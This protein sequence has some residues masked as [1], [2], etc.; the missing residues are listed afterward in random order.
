V[1]GLY[2]CFLAAIVLDHAHLVCPI[3][4][5]WSNRGF[6]E[7]MLERPEKFILL[8]ALCVASA[9]LVGEHVTTTREPAFRALTAAY[10]WWNAWHFGSQHFGV[11]SLLGWRWGPRW[12]RQ[13]IIIGP[14]MAVMLAPMMLANSA[15]PLVIAGGVFG[16]AHWATDIGLTTRVLRRWWFLPIVLAIGLIGFAWKTVVAGP[17]FCDPLPVCTAVWSVPMLLSLRY[18]IGFWH[19]LMSRWVWQF[20]NPRVRATIGRSLFKRPQLRLVA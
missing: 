5:G 10:I 17:R 3:W 4:L 2:A 7:Y 19:F 8:P 20:S 9:L 11:A 16:L 18:G 1:T 15:L 12:A 13:V 14:T 6:R